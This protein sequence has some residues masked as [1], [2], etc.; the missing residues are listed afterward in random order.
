VKKKLKFVFILIAFSLLGI[1]IFQSYWTV[2]AYKVNKDKFDTNV[3]AAMQNAMDDCKKDYF[4]S[5]RQ[6]L[7]KRLS[8]PETVIKID[9]VPQ[10]GMSDKQGPFVNYEILLLHKN[11][12]PP[13][14]Y[15]ISK[16]QFNLYSNKITHKATIAEMVTEVSFYIPA[17]MEQIRTSLIAEDLGSAFL[18]ME[19]IQKQYPNL[20]STAFTGLPIMAFSIKYESHDSLNR[21]PAFYKHARDSVITAYFKLRNKFPTKMPIMTLGNNQIRLKNLSSLSGKIR[22]A[23]VVTSHKP[24]PLS[25]IVKYKEPAVFVYPP[26]YREAD[27]LKLYRY[28]QSELHKF[29]ILSPFDLVISLRSSPAEKLNNH[30]TETTEVTYKYQGFKVFGTGDQEFFIRAR[31]LTPQ[32]SVLKSML[33]TMFLS[34]FLVLFLIFC[35]NYIIR[36]FIEQRKLGELKDDFISNMTHELKTPIATITVAIEGLQNF[37]ALDDV[38]KTQRYLQTSRNELERLNNLVTKVL[39]IAAFENK[40]IK[41]V[42]EH[43]NIKDLVN[44]VI[45]SEKLKTTKKVDISFVNTNNSETVYVDKFHFR[46]VL[47]NLVDNAV[48]YSNEPVTIMISCYK[49][50]GHLNVFSVKDNGIGIPAAHIGLVF[51]KFHRVPTGNVHAVKGTGL[52]LSYVK[53]I[54]E[55]HG[56]SISVKSELNK[57]S[58]FIVS[59]P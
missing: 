58:E 3:N 39:D 45:A 40:E 53:Y 44:D 57:G 23:L 13:E 1:I 28:F 49:D 21:A 22:K 31:F 4:D 18:T 7:I 55:A 17:L 52:G 29:N 56:G 59:I 42:K 51:D 38:E 5:I 14:P 19:E 6:V 16:S 41:L 27:S 54:V 26:N 47:I 46:N 30:Y 25:P 34:L 32:Y 50:G 33:L 36:T 2:N 20:A 43:I 9:T 11:I 8:P 10:F 24:T 12:L 37:N 15:S 35:F 48:K